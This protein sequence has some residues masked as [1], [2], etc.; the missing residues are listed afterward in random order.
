MTTQDKLVEL[1]LEGVES[2]HCAL[3]VDKGLAGVKGIRTHQVELNNRRALIGADDPASV[4]EAIRAIRDLGYGV[5]T[6][7]ETFG[8]TGMSCASCAVSVE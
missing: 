6:V 3:I 1:P 4:L 5:P 8:V 7:Q 2:E